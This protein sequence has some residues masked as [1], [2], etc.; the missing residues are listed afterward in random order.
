M[1]AADGQSLGQTACGD[2]PRTFNR[3]NEISTISSFCPSY[4]SVYSPSG[5]VLEDDGTGGNLNGGPQISQVTYVWGAIGSGTEDLVSEDQTH[6][7]AGTIGTTDRVYMQNDLTF[8]VT[9]VLRSDGRVRLR[10]G[11]PPSKASGT[12][13][14]IHRTA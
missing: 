10:N 8:S 1:E 12:G 13:D 6:R 7:R 9:S 5:Q 14:F 3:Q 11:S 2:Q 4:T